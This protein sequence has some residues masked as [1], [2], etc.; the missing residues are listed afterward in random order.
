MRY[1]KLFWIAI[2]IQF[3]LPFSWFTILPESALMPV[4][5]LYFMFGL[6][7]LYF[8]WNLPGVHKKD[9]LVQ[10]IGISLTGWMVSAFF[11]FIIA[12]TFKL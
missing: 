9:Y 11:G 2:S 12:W 6:S 4:I 8:A 7:A 3:A 10:G 1:Y 5:F